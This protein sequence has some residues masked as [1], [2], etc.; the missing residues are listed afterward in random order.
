MITTSVDVAAPPQVV[1]DLVSD[2]PNM[3]KWAAETYRCDWLDGATGP[4]VGARFQ[5]RNQHGKARW[6][7]VSSVTDADP[8]RL[9]AFK[10]TLWGMPVARW[11]Y[12]IEP[13]AGGCRV[14]E[15]NEILANW[16]IQRVLAPLGTGVKDRATHNLRNMERTL[17]QLKQAAE[18]RAAT[19][20]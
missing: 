15:T 18:E 19:R 11:G 20:S 3:P 10:V 8:G 9:F 5:G 4:S 6:A 17:A 13:T 14:T 16:F 2:V 12:R 1:Y 7:T